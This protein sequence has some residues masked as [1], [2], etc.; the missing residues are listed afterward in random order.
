MWVTRVERVTTGQGEQREMRDG[1]ITCFMPL[2]LALVTH[3][4]LLTPVTGLSRRD[5]LDA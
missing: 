2:T 1:L 5:V 3:F 4:T